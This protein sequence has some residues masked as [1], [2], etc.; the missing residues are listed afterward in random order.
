MYHVKSCVISGSFKK[1][2]IGA[3]LTHPKYL[4]NS[5]SLYILFI[6]L[7][8]SINFKENS[9]TLSMTLDHS[10]DSTAKGELK[11]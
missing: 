9:R 4:N 11:V 2:E 5:R 6:T 3:S 7:F 10:S 8:S 1:E